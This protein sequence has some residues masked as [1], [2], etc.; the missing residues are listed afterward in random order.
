MYIQKYIPNF[1]LEYGLSFGEYIA[2]CLTVIFRQKEIKIKRFDTKKLDKELNYEFNK[3]FIYH[4]GYDITI[5]RE[6]NDVEFN[7]KISKIP[8]KAKLRFG[9]EL[10]TCL[11]LNC[12]SDLLKNDK[13]IIKNRENLT[14]IR[15][16]NN[17]DFDVKNL[18]FDKKKIEK[19][20]LTKNELWV[21]MLIT[22]LKY[23]IIPFLSNEF[24][25]LFPYGYIALH[26]KNRKV[27]YEINFIDATVKPFY[28]KASF[29]QLIFTQD[30]SVRCGDTNSEDENISIHCEIV[31]PILY[32]IEELEILYDNLISKICNYN[33]T[34]AGFHVN[35]SCVDENDEYINLT[36]AAISEMLP[37]WIKFESLNYVKFRGEEGTEYAE[38]IGPIVK[39][40]DKYSSL[41]KNKDGTP[42]T[43]K[44]YS[45]FSYLLNACVSEKYRTIFFK[46]INLVEFRIFPSK[47]TKE[48]LI[49]YTKDATKIFLKSVKRYIKNAPQIINNLQ[50]HAKE[51]SYD[52]EEIKSY[53]GPIISFYDLLA[54]KKQFILA[55]YHT[56]DL[57][58]LTRKRMYKNPLYI[59]TIS[60]IKDNVK[61]RRYIYDSKDKSCSVYLYDELSLEQVR[62]I[63]FKINKIK[64][65]KS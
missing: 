1:M 33:D 24:K 12:K 59:I 30:S 56:E 55:S 28:G 5:E 43:Q 50:S 25:T 40:Y 44:E 58:T 54:N 19:E 36:R 52:F 8:K 35:V 63:Q 32:D 16:K 64:K 21:D 42:L 41:V 10:E 26:P 23:N 57:D 62:E 34:S 7:F 13:I 17:L 38:E 2:T 29:D 18:I 65:Q 4:D 39:K 47:N 60:Y 53:N 37:E 48:D 15:Q 31:S 46:N 14:K 6:I 11:M 51:L 20:E 3:N 22:Y 61:Y 49:S 27:N 9:C 45:D